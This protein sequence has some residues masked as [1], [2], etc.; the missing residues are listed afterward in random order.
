MSVQVTI[1]IFSGLPNP[2]VT[3]DGAEASELL[4][5]LQPATKLAGADAVPA[6]ESILGYRGVLVEQ[7]GAIAKGGVPARARVVGEKVYAQDS[8]YLPQDPAIETFILGTTGFSKA[9]SL[10]PGLAALMRQEMQ[11]RIVASKSKPATGSTTQ[12]TSTLLCRCAPLYEPDWWNDGGQIQLHNNCYNYACNYR[13]DTFAQPGRAGGVR[14]TALSCPG[15]KPSALSDALLDNV[16]TKV[17]RCP[18]EGN[19][20]ALVIW[21]GFDFH[22]YRM[23]RDGLW[24]HKPGNGMVTNLD[25]NGKVITDPRT[26]DRGRYTD[27]CTFLTVMNGHIKIN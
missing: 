16:T 2:V 12:S 3:L 26:A 14:M 19:L 22:W 9:T 4:K 1:D 13:T 27:F 6:P 10:M 15:V 5:R 8:A 21:P 18:E 11:A 25:N 24:T 23:G 7:A 20:V 17:I